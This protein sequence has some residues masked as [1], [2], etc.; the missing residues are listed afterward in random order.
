MQTLL[1][2]PKTSP[3]PL[4]IVSLLGICVDVKIRLKNVKDDSLKVL[5][6]ALKVRFRLLCQMSSHW[7]LQVDVL[8]FY[9]SNVLMSKTP[10]GAH[11]VV[12][13]RAVNLQAH[14]RLRRIAVCIA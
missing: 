8:N 5:D 6:P 7:F 10:V 12:R 2:K 11:T 14:K 13:V 4:S 9:G 3:T 1:L